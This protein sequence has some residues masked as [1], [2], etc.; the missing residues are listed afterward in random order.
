M[1]KMVTVFVNIIVQI[2]F[3]FLLI[4]PQNNL[5]NDIVSIILQL[6]SKQQNA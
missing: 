6:T 2:M 1:D 5:G 3:V 4:R